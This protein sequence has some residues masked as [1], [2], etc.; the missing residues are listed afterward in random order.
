VTLSGFDDAVREEIISL[1]PDLDLTTGH[2]YSASARPS[3]RSF[4]AAAL[5]G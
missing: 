5:F 3:L 2:G 4:E 1:F